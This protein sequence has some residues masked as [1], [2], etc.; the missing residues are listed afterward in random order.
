MLTVGESRQVDSFGQQHLH[1]EQIEMAVFRN[2]F[3]HHP[4]RQK[5]ITAPLLILTMI[6]AEDLGYVRPACPSRPFVQSV[7][8]VRPSVQSV[9]S[10]PC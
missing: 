3:E 4:A 8:P 6:P 1:F 9:Q 5:H 2:Q 7:R 10:R